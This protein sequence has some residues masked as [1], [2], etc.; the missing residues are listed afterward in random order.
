MNKRWLLVCCFALTFLAAVSIPA[1]AQFTDPR[2]YTNSPIGINQLELGYTY[3]HTN[4]SLDASLV[5]AGARLN[6]NQGTLD[7]TRYFGLFH[8]LTWVEAAVPIAGL[9]GEVSGTNIAGS[10]TGTGDSSYNFAMLLKGGTAL[11]VSQ[12]E[13]YES[14]TALGASFTITAP[15]GLYSSDKILNLGSDRWSFKPEVG[16]SYP[17]G[18]KQKWELD[19]YANA[20]FYTN[21]TSYHGHEILRQDPLPGVEGHIS[22]SFSD[23]LWA[24]LD[25]RYS[26]RGTTF[27]NDVDQSN[28]QRN[29]ILGSELNVSLNSRNSLVL[30]FAKAMVHRNG[31]ALTGFSLRYDYIWGAGLK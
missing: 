31:P 18:N 25:T 12:F 19:A 8:R 17:F 13:N 22:Y 23:N 11:S 6:L 29:F 7:Y 24:S 27:L 15:T 14:R 21:N 16:L 2:T 3:V 10:T 28:T 20:Y 5:V 9:G 4:A 30:E 26:F 1:R